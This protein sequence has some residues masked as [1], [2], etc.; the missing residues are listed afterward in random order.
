MIKGEI[1]CITCLATEK[2][3]IGQTIRGYR[4]NNSWI[5]TTLSSPLGKGFKWENEVV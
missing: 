3:Y 2:K 5:S 1:Y 4:S